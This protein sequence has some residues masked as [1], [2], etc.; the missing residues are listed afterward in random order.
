MGTLDG[1]VEHLDQAH[2]GRRRREKLL[3]VCIN[4]AGLEVVPQGKLEIRAA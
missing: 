3:S 1:A 4:V 2:R